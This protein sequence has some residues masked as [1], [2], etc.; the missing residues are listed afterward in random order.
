MDG[1]RIDQIVHPKITEHLPISH[2]TVVLPSLPDLIPSGIRLRITV[3][4]SQEGRFHG[5][6]SDRFG[7]IID[8]GR[9]GDSMSRRGGH[10]AERSK[11]I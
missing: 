6:P 7:R 3:G 8:E 5:G 11:R 9:I 4:N 10:L 1:S 2:G